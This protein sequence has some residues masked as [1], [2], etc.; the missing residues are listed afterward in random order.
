MFH[1][2]SVCSAKLTGRSFMF[3]IQE[4]KKANFS[5][6]QMRNS[7]ILILNICVEHLEKA[8]NV[9]LVV[10]LVSFAKHTVCVTQTCRQL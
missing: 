2:F 4:S 6:C 8:A 5:K 1:C 9:R 10:S 3:T 7:L